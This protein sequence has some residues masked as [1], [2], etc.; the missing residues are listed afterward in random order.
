MNI[1]ITENILI[2][3]FIYQL[4]EFFG[5][6]YTYYSEELEQGF[7]RPSFHVSRIDDIHSKG[8]T[9]HQYKMR[10]DNY[11]FLIKYF[12]NV[13]DREKEDINNKIDNLKNLFDYLHII[14][15]KDGKVYS[16]PNRISSINISI[17]ED[18]L[19][20]EVVVPVR[21]VIYLDI[22]KVKENYLTEG[23]K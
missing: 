9:G 10:D 16:K 22:N 12:T 17:Q 20:F 18:V 15:I 11:R 5:K 4:K 1:E 21:T 14:N 8:Y 19:F 6:D 2:G 3:S 13:K 23:L 7:K